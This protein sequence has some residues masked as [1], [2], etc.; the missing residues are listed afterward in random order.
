MDELFVLGQRTDQRVYL[1]ERQLLLLGHV[2]I[3]QVADGA[4][5]EGAIGVGDVA[6]VF[7]LFG[8]I[9]PGQARQALQNADAFDAA[10][11]QQ[12]LGPACAARSDAANAP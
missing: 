4:Q 5:A 1:C 3:D 12:G 2:P 11:L 10:D 9:A 6:G 7:D 8:A